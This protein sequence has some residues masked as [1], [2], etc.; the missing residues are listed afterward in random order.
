MRELKI[1]S[2]RANLALARDICQFLHLDIGS[3]SL[4]KFPD[5]ENFCKIEDDVRGRDVYLIQPTSPPVNDNLME[6]LIMIDSCKRASAA[7]ITAVIPYFGYARQD[8]KDEGRVPI[9][10]KLAANI[11]TRAGADRVLTMDLH[12][13]QIQGFFDVPVDHLYAAPVLN[14][15]FLAMGIDPSEIVVVSPDE[16]SIKR[17]I[18]HSKRMGG[19]L[20]I[21][22]K[23][24]DNAMETR[25][26]NIIGGPIEGKICLMFDDMIS[27]AGSICGAAT[28]VHEAGAKQIHVAAT[29]GVLCG[30]AI[31]RLKEAPIDTVVI[32]NSI[33]LTTDKIIPKMTVLSVAPLL[34]E[35]IKRIHHN[36]SISQMFGTER[37]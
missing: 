36:K 17:A 1:F 6:L 34:A 31:Q 2:G 28:L 12:A 26:K 13:P 3:I 37:E 9:T 22:D 24:R 11:I 4:G 27:T 23:R 32:T 19:K 8:R 21:V 15:H 7:R 25:Q 18:G 29:H 14:Q 10:A 20:A 5:G 30:P 33:P 16:G 35:A